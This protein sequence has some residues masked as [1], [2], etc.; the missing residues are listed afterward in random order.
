MKIIPLYPLS[1]EASTVVSDEDFKWASQYK[2]YMANCGKNCAKWYVRMTLPFGTKAKRDEVKRE[3]GVTNVYLHREILKRMGII[4]T[5]ELVAD[6]INQNSLDNRR[7]N[8]RL[9]TKSENFANRK[10]KKRELQMQTE[11]G[12]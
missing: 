12:R 8:L 11:R 2:W 3:W 6:H 1:D 10:R 7:E 5:P 4:L 9:V